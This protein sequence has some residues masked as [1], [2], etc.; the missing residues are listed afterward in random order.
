M[1]L[2]SLALYAARFRCKVLPFLLT[3]H[4]GHGD[5]MAMDYVATYHKMFPKPNILH[6]HAR[7]KSVII[8]INQFCYLYKYKLRQRN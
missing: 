8:I 5:N 7:I 4:E 3:R 6:E 1:I 2:I